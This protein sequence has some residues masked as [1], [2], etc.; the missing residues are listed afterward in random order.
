MSILRRIY[1]KKCGLTL[2]QG[3]GTTTYIKKPGNFLRKLFGLG[4][5]KIILPDP[6]TSSFSKKLGG[7]TLQDFIEAGQMGSITAYICL[8]CLKTFNL[9]SDEVKKCPKCSDTN[10]KSVLKLVGQPCPKCKDGVIENK[11]IGI[12]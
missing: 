2:L 12:T 8:S 10:I 3:V 4:D 9:D 5:Q 1:C 6:P 11:R 7:K